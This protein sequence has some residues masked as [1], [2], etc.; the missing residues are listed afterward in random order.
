MKFN[1]APMVAFRSHGL[2]SS[3][4]AKC[5]LVSVVFVGVAAT[6]GNEASF[7]NARFF[8]RLFPD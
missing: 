1:R 5:R 6:Y 8:L 4:Q 7:K 3:F 2:F